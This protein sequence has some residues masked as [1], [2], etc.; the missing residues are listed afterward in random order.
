MIFAMNKFTGLFSIIFTLALTSCDFNADGISTLPDNLKAAL[1][2]YKNEKTQ[3]SVLSSSSEDFHDE[4]SRKLGGSKGKITAYS[5]PNSLEAETSR[6]LLKEI[7]PNKFIL[8]VGQDLNYL[9]L[10]L[11][12]LT[13]QTALGT[14]D[15]EDDF[16]GD[17]RFHWLFKY[18]GDYVEI[19]LY[20]SSA[21]GLEG[22][23]T[24]YLQ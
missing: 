10:D 11:S 14:F 5:L 24:I 8:A 1:N 19:L 18:A 15:L 22:V 6:V 23:M 17:G 9:E 20:S 2:S 16:S 13:L 21:E 4:V 7:K 12:K 3:N